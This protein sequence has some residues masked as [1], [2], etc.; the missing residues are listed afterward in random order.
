[1]SQ[2]YLLRDVLRARAFHF[3][4]KSRAF[5]SLGL[6]SSG[7]LET[8]LNDPT[9]ERNFLMTKSWRFS[10]EWLRKRWNDRDLEEGDPPVPPFLLE[11]FKFQQDWLRP[12]TFNFTLKKGKNGTKRIQFKKTQICDIRILTI[13]LKKIV[14]LKW[15]QHCLGKMSTNFDQFFAFRKIFRFFL[16]KM[17]EIFLAP[18]FVK[19]DVFLDVLTHDFLFFEYHFFRVFF[20]FLVTVQLK[21]MTLCM[22]FSQK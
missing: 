18:K 22:S 10:R 8:L 11:A 12:T 6:N 7:M 13:F 9:E 4:P 17:H 16:E 5:T 1:M 14:K 19:I 2:F 20:V 15:H 21:K 3:N